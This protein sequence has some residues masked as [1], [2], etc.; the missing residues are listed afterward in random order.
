M[1]QI[2]SIY[3]IGGKPGFRET[4]SPSFLVY[5]FLEFFGSLLSQIFPKISFHETTLSEN[6]CI[7]GRG[8]QK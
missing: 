8:W 3:I 1:R 7:W 2:I 4:D 5:K 6:K